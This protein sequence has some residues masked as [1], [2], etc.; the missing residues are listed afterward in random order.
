MR[1]HMDCHR[2]AVDNIIVAPEI[3]VGGRGHA[4]KQ[5]GKYDPDNREH[6]IGNKTN[7]RPFPNGVRTARF[8]ILPNKVEDQADDGKEKRERVK[9]CAGAVL[10]LLIGRLKGCWP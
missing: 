9:A 2:H 1:Q 6:N 3:I 7:Q 5:N 8:L 4:V 10:L